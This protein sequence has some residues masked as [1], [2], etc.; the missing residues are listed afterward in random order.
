MQEIKKQ[1]FFCKN[2]LASSIFNQV[3]F[4][5]RMQVFMICTTCTGT[6]IQYNM[7]HIISYG[8]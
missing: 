4:D 7:F 5:G 3:K 6:T 2:F 8:K 1:L